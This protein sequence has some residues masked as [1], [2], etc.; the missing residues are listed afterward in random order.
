MVEKRPARD[1]FS[2]VQRT[3]VEKRTIWGVISTC[4]GARAETM[5]LICL[6]DYMD[7][8]SIT[9]GFCVEDLNIVLEW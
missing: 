8:N 9:D 4:V 3:F 1:C 5:Y 7:S 2:L 6:V